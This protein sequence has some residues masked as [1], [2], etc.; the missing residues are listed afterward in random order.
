MLFQQIKGEDCEIVK[1][2]IRSKVKSRYAVTSV[3][4]TMKNLK[5]RHDHNGTSSC[6]FKL[7]LPKHTILSKLFM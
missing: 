6:T 3:I 1:L 2:E 7:P 5:P 4:T